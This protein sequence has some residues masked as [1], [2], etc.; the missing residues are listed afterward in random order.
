MHY[1]KCSCGNIWR[2]TD[3]KAG[4]EKA[5]TCSKCG[6][7]SWLRFTRDGFYKLTETEYKDFL[8]KNNLTR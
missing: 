6:R 8:R 4:D 3:R 5:H 7:Q 2:H 1:H